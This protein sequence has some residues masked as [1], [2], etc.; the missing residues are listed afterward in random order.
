MP[1]YKAVIAY[2]GT[3]YAGFQ[4]QQNAHT[5]Q[6]EIE[7]TLRRFNKGKSITIHPSGRTDSGVHAKGQVI[8]FDYPHER[9]SVIFRFA[10]DTQ[11]PDD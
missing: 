1:R 7:N 3:N 9:D 10:V 5:V 8:H 11:T 4:V 2:D 6:A